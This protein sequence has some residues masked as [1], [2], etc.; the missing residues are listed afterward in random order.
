[1]MKFGYAMTSAR[2]LP[3]SSLLS[4]RPQWVLRPMARFP[5]VFFFCVFVVLAGKRTAHALTASP[6]RCGSADSASEW[7]C[8]R[9]WQR[10]GVGGLIE[11]RCLVLTESSRGWVVFLRL[12]LEIG[13]ALSDS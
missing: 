4:A 5:I 13:L 2:H 7:A 11:G 3:L 6:R 12:L 10:R 8:L 1:M 9:A